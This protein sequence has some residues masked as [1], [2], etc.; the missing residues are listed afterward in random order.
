ML[1]LQSPSL[2][3]ANQALLF[4]GEL[5]KFKHSNSRLS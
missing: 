5:S 1:K 2:K 3:P 4:I